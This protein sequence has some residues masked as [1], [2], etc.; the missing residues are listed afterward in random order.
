MGI[1]DTYLYSKYYWWNVYSAGDFHLQSRKVLQEK[2][3]NK[4]KKKAMGNVKADMYIGTSCD[5]TSIRR[6]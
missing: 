4:S 2:W 3:M 5:R 1:C 6:R